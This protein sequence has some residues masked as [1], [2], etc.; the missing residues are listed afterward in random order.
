MKRKKKRKKKQTNKNNNPSVCITYY[1]LCA[2]AFSLLEHDDQRTRKYMYLCMC[3][4]QMIPNN[5]IGCNTWD[6]YDVIVPL[7]AV[8][9]CIKLRI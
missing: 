7:D 5:V 9:R 8:S 3:R 6:Q 2:H 1:K 4:C